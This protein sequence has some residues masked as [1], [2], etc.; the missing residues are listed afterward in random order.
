M[1]RRV[2]FSFKYLDVSRAM[3]VR[4]SW[5]TKGEAAGFVDAAAFENIKRQGDAAIQRWI[6]GQLQNTSV[7]VVLVG[8]KTCS[9][10]WVKYEIEQSVKRGN[11][12]LGIDISKIKGLDGSTTER[13]GEIPKG[14]K[15]YLWNNDKGYENL[16]KW[17]EEAAAAAGR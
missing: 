4:N 8:A 14:Y 7:T 2:F 5:V 11:G 1:A 10:R 12:L 16:G 9:S 17:I 3:V 13:C 15:F 6:D